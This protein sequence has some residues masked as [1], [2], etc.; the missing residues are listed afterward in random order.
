MKS[1]FLRD[2]QIE[3]DRFKHA[4]NH[5]ILT[6]E[7][8]ATL[9]SILQKYYAISGFLD[10]PIALNAD[11]IWKE[12]FIKLK[13]DGDWKAL[14]TSQFNS[15]N[16]I[17][18]TSYMKVK[19]MFFAG[20]DLYKEGKASMI[21]KVFN[22]FKVIN[23][24]GPQLSQSA[25]ITSFCEFMLI[26]GYALQDYVSWE[27][28]D[29]TTIRGTLKDH[30]FEVSGLFSFDKEG[31]F[32]Y[33][34]TDDRYYDEGDGNYV[35][36]K[37]LARFDSYKQVDGALQVENITALWRLDD[38]DYEYYKGTIDHIVYNVRE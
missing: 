32:K 11:I 8:I 3:I 2:R 15:V 12:S 16:P 25:L 20:K 1:T 24:S 30:A 34:E 5:D 27:E 10:K 29:D 36:K 26:S 18:R 22:L 38:G 21:G 33:F 6:N 14:K 13:R 35:K 28:I 31:K 23:A 4:S 17:M 7:K 37:F 9:P 19:R